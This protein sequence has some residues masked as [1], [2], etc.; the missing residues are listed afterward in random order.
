MPLPDSINLAALGLAGAEAVVLHG[1]YARGDATATSD[2]D[3][4]AIY[5]VLDGRIP[6]F[7]VNDPLINFQLDTKATPV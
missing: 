5:K 7:Q 2:V 3:L 4:H 1:S 6:T